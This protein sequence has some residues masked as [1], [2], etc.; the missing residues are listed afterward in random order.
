MRVAVVGYGVIGRRVASG[1]RAQPDMELA[2]VVVRGAGPPAAAAALRGHSVFGSDGR[3][4]D[5]LA[6]AGLEC[7]GDTDDLLARSGAVVDC[8]P[9]RTAEARLAAYQA[10]GVPVALG[11]GESADLAE[12]TVCS[13]VNYD[14][15]R[16][17]SVVRVASCNVTGLAR[18]L[19]PLQ[20]HFGVRGA[21]A[22]LVRC[23]ADPNKGAKGVV[24]GAEL[25]TGVSHHAED[26]QRIIPGI[27]LHTQALSVPMTQGHVVMMTIEFG[28][29]VALNDLV[30][31]YSSTPR[32]LLDWRESDSTGAVTARA[33]RAGRER[34]DWP[35]VLLYACSL[36]MSRTRLHLMAAIHMESIVIPDTIDSV[37]AMVDPGSD[38]AASLRTTDRALGLA[39]PAWRYE[40]SRLSPSTGRPR[41][42]SSQRTVAADQRVSRAVVGQPGLLD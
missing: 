6:K 31:L 9:S 29:E 39:N 1:L 10:I 42:E 19:A 14:D 15:A 34:G 25:R 2:G 30:D 8:G 37:R 24:D 41:D 40:P 26:V 16:G 13:S 7:A 3:A 5:M 33:G 11:G 21:S 32:V 28:R 12:V 38:A 22:T 36:A 35:E 27:D 4:C 18:L 23:A 20:R 17:R